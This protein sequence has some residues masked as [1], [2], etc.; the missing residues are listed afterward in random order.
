MPCICDVAKGDGRAGLE[1]LTTE[2]KLRTSVT[3]ADSGAAVL[4][5]YGDTALPPWWRLIVTQRCVVCAR[6][7]AFAIESGTSLRLL[8]TGNAPRLDFLS[9]G[10]W[11]YVQ[12]NDL[13]DGFQ[14]GSV[15]F[16][17]APRISAR[18]QRMAVEIAS[19]ITQGLAFLVCFD[20]RECNRAIRRIKDHGA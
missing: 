19:K 8:D 6:R 9:A 14:P 12:C 13:A 17:N 7:G 5:A 1:G 10:S 3:S 16:G 11:I 20:G 15:L 2:S 18:W 4:P